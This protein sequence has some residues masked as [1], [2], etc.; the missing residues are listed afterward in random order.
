MICPLGHCWHYLAVFS[1]YQRKL[2]KSYFPREMGLLDGLGLSEMSDHHPR[3]QFGGRVDLANKI[4]LP[5]VLSRRGSSCRTEAWL[6]AGNSSRPYLNIRYIREC[7]ELR[8]ARQ[9]LWEELVGAENAET[10]LSTPGTTMFTQRAEEH[11]SGGL[12]ASMPSLSPADRHSN[13]ALLQ[14]RCS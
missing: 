12:V 3:D 9:S 1:S 6:S 10:C 13:L 4:L 14:P 7:G 11:Q 2:V 8:L 5:Q